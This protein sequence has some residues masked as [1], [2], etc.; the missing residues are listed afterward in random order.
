M[1]GGCPPV[2]DVTAA[3]IKAAVRRLQ[4]ETDAVGPGERSVR[5]VV[6]LVCDAACCGAM[7]PSLPSAAAVGA[8]YARRDRDGRIAAQAGRLSTRQLAERHALSK[9]Q[10]RRIIGRCPRREGG[11][12]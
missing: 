10:I 3:A 4:V 9:R 6:A 12:T 1:T 11:H 8:A 7:R 2:A 5:L